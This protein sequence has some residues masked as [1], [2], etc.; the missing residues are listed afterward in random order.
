M[1]ASYLRCLLAPLLAL[2]LLRHLQLL[3]LHASPLSGGHRSTWHSG[4]YRVVFGTEEYMA[5]CRARHPGVWPPETFYPTAAVVFT[6]APDQVP[7]V[8]PLPHPLHHPYH[9][10]HKLGPAPAA[11]ALFSPRGP[12]PCAASGASRCGILMC[13]PGPVARARHCADALPACCIKQML[14]RTNC[15]KNHCLPNRNRGTIVP[16]PGR[17]DPSSLACRCTSISTY[18]SRGT[19]TATAPTAEAER[20]RPWGRGV[21]LCCT[22][23]V[24]SNVVCH[25][26]QATNTAHSS[27][28]SVQAVVD[29]LTV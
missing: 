29:V 15:T 3:L 26:C 16:G 21:V 24:Q 20:Q 11:V 25:A 28:E 2:Q 27:A 18:P 14:F 22:A 9:R 4:R 23:P 13:S 6:C 5:S 19:R 8:L 17:D 1:I 10:S 7:L 12:Q